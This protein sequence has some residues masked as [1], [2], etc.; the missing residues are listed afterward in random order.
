MANRSLIG[1][2]KLF[3]EPNGS[4]TKNS[5]TIALN[6]NNYPTEMKNVQADWLDV[7]NH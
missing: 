7:L 6:L 3:F 2:I 5:K 4:S 1:I